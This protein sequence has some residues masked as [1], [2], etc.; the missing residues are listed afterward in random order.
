MGTYRCT[1]FSSYKNCWWN[2]V[3]FNSLSSKTLN[4]S[5]LFSVCVLTLS[6]LISLNNLTAWEVWFEE[7]FYRIINSAEITIQ[8]KMLGFW[9]W[10]NIVSKFNV[11]IHLPSPRQRVISLPQHCYYRMHHLMWEGWGGG[12]WNSEHSFEHVITVIRNKLTTVVLL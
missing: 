7:V 3:N 1:Y 2:L 12:E 10:E 11:C 8:I 5:S 6:S 4:I 9:L